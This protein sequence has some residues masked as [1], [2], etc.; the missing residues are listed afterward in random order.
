MIELGV[1]A[2]EID[3]PE[4]FEQGSWTANPAAVDVHSPELFE[5]RSRTGNLTAVHIHSPELIEQGNRTGNL[6]AVHIHSPELIEQGNRAGNLTVDDVHGPESIEQGNRAGNLTVEDVLDLMDDFPPLLP[7]WSSLAYGH[8][9]FPG[10]KR[11]VRHEVVAH[12]L[13]ALVD[14]HDWQPSQHP[15]VDPVPAAVE[16]D[17]HDTPLVA[18]L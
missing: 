9:V 3:S 7:N 4:M 2:V 11:V 1:A 16:A 6:T 8:D 13:V 15:A 5:Q 17:S 18:F 10:V 12:F 14:G